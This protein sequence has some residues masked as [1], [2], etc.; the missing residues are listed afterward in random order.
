MGV[1][2]VESG[3]GGIRCAGGGDTGPHAELHEQEG[4]HYCA[5]SHGVMRGHMQKRRKPG[6]P[7]AEPCSGGL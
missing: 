7:A 4:S 2:A 6:A 3:R 1:E 5:D